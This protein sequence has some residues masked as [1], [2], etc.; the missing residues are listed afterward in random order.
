VEEVKEYVQKK[1]E[2][3]KKKKPKKKKKT[4]NETHIIFPKFPKNCNFL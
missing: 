4:T 3:K 2:E 1:K